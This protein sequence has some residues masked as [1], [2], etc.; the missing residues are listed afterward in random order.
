MWAVSVR[1]SIQDTFLPIGYP[2]SVT[3]DY[4]PYQIWD[5]LQAFCSTITGLFS[6]Q[7]MFVSVGVGDAAASSLGGIV[8]LM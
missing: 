8:F 6:T 4:T 2:L 7:A 5:S 3:P 1:Q